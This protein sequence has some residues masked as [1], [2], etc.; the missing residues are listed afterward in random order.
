M[1]PGAFIRNLA[2]SLRQTVL[3]DI[4]DS[5]LP[6]LPPEIATE[7]QALRREIE[8][9]HHRLLQERI[10]FGSG[11]T[12]SAISA[13]LRHSGLSRR[14]GGSQFA[15]LLPH[16]SAFGGSRLTGFSNGIG[17]NANRKL[18]GRQLLDHEAL[19]CLL[20]LLFVDEPRLNTAR[21]H[22][23]LRNLCYHEETRA[24]VI[25]TLISI[26]RRTSGQKADGSCPVPVLGHDSSAT[27]AGPASNSS[28]RLDEYL[29]QSK[30]SGQNGD[31]KTRAHPWL[32]LTVD[33]SL[34][35]RT[36]VFCVNR[37]GKLGLE[38]S[39][40]VAIH[41]HASLF[42]CR[43]VLDILL[44]L[45][46]SFSP[47]FTPCLAKHRSSCDKEPGTTSDQPSKSCS[48]TTGETDFWDILVKLDAAGSGR[49]GKSAAKPHTNAQAVEA[50]EGETEDLDAAPMGQILTMLAHPIIRKDVALTDKL[51][52]LLSIVSASLS[53]APRTVRKTQNASDATPS[54][55]T[56]T[57]ES[58]ELPATPSQ[59]AGPVSTLPPISYTPISETESVASSLVAERSSEAGG[60]RHEVESIDSG[61]ADETLSHSGATEPMVVEVALPPEDLPGRADSESLLL[62][63]ASAS[64]AQSLQKSAEP[65]PD[66]GP[67]IV[68][69]EH[70]RLAV[71]V[72]TS[73]TCSE[74]GL[75]DATTLLL[76][77]ARVNTKTHDSV[78]HLLLEGAR[79]T[80]ELLCKNIKDL[81]LEL[82]EHNRA[83]PAR[84]ETKDVGKGKR[85]VPL[86]MPSAPRRPVRTARGGRLTG[87]TAGRRAVKPAGSDL[88]LPSMPILTCKTSNQA[89]LLRVLKVILQ[90]RE[91]ARKSVKHQGSGAPSRRQQ[92]RRGREIRPCIVGKHHIE[93]VRIPLKA[94]NRRFPSCI[95]PLFQ[96]ESLCEAFHMEIS[97]I[98]M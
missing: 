62:T 52:R 15:R 9:R 67:S 29:Q 1:D 84:E 82:V 64:T 40:H 72:L 17:L 53:E 49:K 69:E 93:S 45:A 54:G 68:M 57:S 51:L 95:S 42:V 48:T 37:Q 34:G 90:L 26:L 5:L 76:Q 12:A 63:T 75:E 91:A 83:A 74:E 86:V 60:E 4:D 73:G 47:S 16:G 31:K 2:P 77:I 98:H 92:Q 88:H 55:V 30:E 24:W 28:N 66:E 18:A 79:R 38:R 11:D 25:G 32:S 13:L 59:D 50:T 22:K 36:S 78:L 3:A 44:F 7:A 56:N 39:S 19:T 81:L 58:R 27:G 6:L 61:S 35:C 89:L 41:P 70:L 87:T 10:A 14:T 8:A 94:Q 71:S 96:S 65:L 20:V 43:H 46:K 80:G 21:L 97:F 85:P 33:A 23:V